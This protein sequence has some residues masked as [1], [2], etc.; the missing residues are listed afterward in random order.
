LSPKAKSHFKVVFLL[1]VQNSIKIRRVIRIEYR[2]LG[3]KWILAF[4]EN[5]KETVMVNETTLRNK[6]K[7]IMG[8]DILWV[9]PSFGSTVGLPDCELRFDGKTF[10]VELKFWKV[11]RFGLKCELRPAQIRYHVVSA[12]TKIKTAILFAYALAGSESDYVM[13]LLS[14]RKCP[15]ENY[16][17]KIEQAEFIGYRSDDARIMKR[18]IQNILDNEGFWD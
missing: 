10:P 16:A 3:P 9:E 17:V 8:K 15:K 11:T 12:R 18:R 14:N 13:Y 6:I 5:E 7:S 4:G 1:F 2:K